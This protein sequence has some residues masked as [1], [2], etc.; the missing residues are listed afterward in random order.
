[1][2]KRP[3]IRN[4]EKFKKNGCPQKEWDEETGEGCPYWREIETQTKGEQVPSLKKMCIDEWMFEFKI[5]ELG[6]IEGNQVAL[7]EFRNGMIY[8]DENGRL[9]PKPDAGMIQLLNYLGKQIERKKIIEEYEKQK[10]LED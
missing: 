8:R 2:K 6:L 10:Q 1:M 9:N 7:E 5:T 4:L 3:C